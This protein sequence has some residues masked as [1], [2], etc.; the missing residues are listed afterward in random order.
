MNEEEKKEGVV[1]RK[2]QFQVTEKPRAGYERGTN[3]C[4]AVQVTVWVPHLPA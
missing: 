1:R 2:F 3:N 4:E